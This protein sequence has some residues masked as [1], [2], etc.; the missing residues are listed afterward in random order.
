MERSAWH[1]ES[2]EGGLN[3]LSI[4]FRTMILVYPAWG[5]WK[6][7]E[8]PDYSLTV[9]FHTDLNILTAAHSTHTSG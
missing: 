9:H 4:F 5:S 1:R 8:S 3:A 2:L 6:E 7:Y